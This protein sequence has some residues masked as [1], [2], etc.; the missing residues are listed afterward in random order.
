MPAASPKRA[1]NGSRNSAS[2][3]PA[4]NSMNGNP[5]PKKSKTNSRDESSV[6]SSPLL[7]ILLTLLPALV[8]YSAANPGFSASIYSRYRGFI[9]DAADYISLGDYYTPRPTLKETL[10]AFD[11]KDYSQTSFAADASRDRIIQVRWKIGEFVRRL[12]TED[13]VD[14]ALMDVEAPSLDSEDRFA[15]L[16]LHAAF[17]MDR[18]RSTTKVR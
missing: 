9:A 13:P 11:E 18:K 6:F 8:A 10:P 2:A 17:A 5:T 1:Q 15:L 7:P 14:K 12:G 3:S 16:K 4:K